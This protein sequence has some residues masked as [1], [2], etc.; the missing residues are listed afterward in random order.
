M[1]SSDDKDMEKPRDSD[2]VTRTMLYRHLA[3]KGYV[4]WEADALGPIK[5]LVD[6]M[7]LQV[8]V[9]LNKVKGDFEMKLENEHPWLH[10]KVRP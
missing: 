6:S 4:V 5:V 7:S 8:W 2:N 3:Y 1:S 10:S 9:R